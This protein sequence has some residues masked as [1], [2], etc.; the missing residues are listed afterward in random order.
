[1]SN[2]RRVGSETA[3]ERQL[4]R[5]QDVPELAPARLAEPLRREVADGVDDD[6]LRTEPRR[7]VDLVPDRALGVESES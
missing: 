1:M 2:G 5:P 3:I 6:A 7:L 4:D